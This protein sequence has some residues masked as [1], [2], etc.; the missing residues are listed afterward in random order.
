MNPL[1]LY[2]NHKKSYDFTQTTQKQT[3]VAVKQSKFN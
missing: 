3:D 2:Q 1:F